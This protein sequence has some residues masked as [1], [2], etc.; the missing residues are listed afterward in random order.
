MLRAMERALSEQSEEESMKYK[1]QQ[2]PIVGRLR[3][4]EAALK[5]ENFYDIP[6]FLSYW[7]ILFSY[8]LDVSYRFVLATSSDG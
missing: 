4:L 2:A 3:G 8:L 5:G 1:A 7:I 6:Y